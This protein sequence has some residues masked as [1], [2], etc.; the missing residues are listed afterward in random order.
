MDKKTL[1]TLV[2]TA[3]VGL[4]GGAYK[5]FCEGHG[6]DVGNCSVYIPI[7]FGALQGS[8]MG[9]RL[10]DNYK[11]YPDEKTGLAKGLVARLSGAALCG[12]VGGC[13]VGVGY[14]LGYIAGRFY[15]LS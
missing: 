11:K 9:K 12:L 2:S 14:S 1:G 13:S 15:H 5:G 4:G 6:L 8:L 7:I 3:I 10:S